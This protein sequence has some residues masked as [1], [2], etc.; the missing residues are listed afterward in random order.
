M[1]E[2]ALS[3]PVD[4]DDVPLAA[5]LSDEDVLGV[6][7]EDVLGVLLEDEELG[8]VDEDEPLMPLEEPMEVS[9]EV[10]PEVEPDFELLL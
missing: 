1:C 2:V 8:L 7:L 4:L 9:L 3:S 5:A 6:L 10:D